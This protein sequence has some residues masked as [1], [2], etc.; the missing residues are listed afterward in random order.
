MIKEI[1]N[2]YDNLVQNHVLEFEFNSITSYNYYEDETITGIDFFEDF[3][4][5]KINENVKNKLNKVF[6]Y[7]DKLHFLIVTPFLKTHYDALKINYF[8]KKEDVELSCYD[9]K[10]DKKFQKEIK[11]IVSLDIVDKLLK[12]WKG[13]LSTMLFLQALENES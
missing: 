11:T 3:F 1:I 6:V 5:Q 4:T 12:K 9:V 10:N 8:Y 2:L 7:K 13:N